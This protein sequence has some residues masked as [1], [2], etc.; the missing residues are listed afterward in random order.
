MTLGKKNCEPAPIAA[1]IVDLDELQAQEVE[2]QEVDVWQ[3]CYDSL[4]DKTIEEIGEEFYGAR[5]KAIDDRVL[6]DQGERLR[7]LTVNK[8]FLETFDRAMS[9]PMDLTTF[10]WRLSKFVSVPDRGLEHY[11]SVNNFYRNSTRQ[12]GKKFIARQ[13]VHYLLRFCEQR[14]ELETE[15]MGIWRDIYKEKLRVG[16]GPKEGLPGYIGEVELAIK[17]N[18]Q[19]AEVKERQ[20]GRLSEISNYLIWLEGTPMEYIS[21]GESPK[22][23]LNNLERLPYY[24]IG[25]ARL[26]TAYAELEN[27]EL[28]SREA[29]SLLIRSP[30][31]LVTF[32]RNALQLDESLR[33]GSLGAIHKLALQQEQGNGIT[34]GWIIKLANLITPALT[35]QSGLQL[36]KIEPALGGYPM[37]VDRI[38]SFTMAAAHAQIEAEGQEGL[39]QLAADFIKLAA[40][41]GVEHKLQQ[42]VLTLGDIVL[43]YPKL[44]AQQHRDMAE[45]LQRSHGS[46]GSTAMQ[47]IY[48]DL[49]T[50]NK[51]H[52]SRRKWQPGY[53]IFS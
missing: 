47:S 31:A 9:Q 38:I 7:R 41:R 22:S 40:L 28:S 11:R 26:S 33:A 49:R 23:M 17:K 6:A 21:E 30:D 45:R 44:S 27:A 25:E 39:Y 18:R 50:R 52:T 14:P 19:P 46:L 53:G 4:K 35:Q 1:P 15:A 51:H 16:S 13:T 10:Q 32:A 3:A 43:R 24:R 34:Y 37:A 36:E 20:L 48:H 2:G 5:G 42:T 12:S 8:V 29:R